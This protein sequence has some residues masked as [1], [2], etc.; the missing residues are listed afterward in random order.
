MRFH[1]LGPLEA[2]GKT[3]P[4][5]VKGHRRRALLAMLL[6]HPGRVVTLP[7][8]VDGIWADR[9]PDSAIANLR[10]YVH[11]LRRLLQRVGDSAARLAS[12]PAGYHLRV[13]PDELDLTRFQALA[14]D[15]RRA[16]RRGDHRGA[17]DRLGQAL[18]LWRGRPLED[19]PAAGS[20]IRANAVALDEERWS[21]A[22]S[23]IDARLA[24]GQCDQVLPLLRRMVVERPLYE[25]TRLQLVLALRGAGR[26]VDALVA[27]RE[28]RRVFV[29]ELG[30]EPGAELQRAHTAI[31]DGRS[32]VPGNR[33]IPRGQSP[34]R[35]G[36]ANPPVAT[37]AVGF[38][39]VGNGGRWPA[40]G[41]A[42]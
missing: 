19:L 2:H 41:A 16:L 22:S 42:G 30:V 29:D 25:R 24:L 31:L 39:S 23:W 18:G 3:G 9:P 8:L 14:S 35:L 1:V 21:V 6:L 4:M 28:A 17:A 11:D 40:I 37:V 26:T 36:R 32:P 5:P 27:Y 13:G 33:S 10:T 38:R 12:H 20:A 15:G 7:A 34:G